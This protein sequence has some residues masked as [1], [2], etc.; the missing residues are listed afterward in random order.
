M[1]QKKTTITPMT[2]RGRGRGRAREGFGRS[3]FEASSPNTRRQ[4]RDSSGSSDSRSSKRRSSPE[5]GNNPNWIPL[6]NSQKLKSKANAKSMLSRVGK[7]R[8]GK[9]KQKGLRGNNE[10]VPYF[11][12]ESRGMTVDNDLATRERK[13]KRA[14]RFASS[15]AKQ[16]APRKQIK[17]SSLNDQL[18]SSDNIEE[19]NV[20]WESWHIVGTCEDLEK[21]FL[22]LTTAPEP[23]NV[24]P[25][26]VLKKSL[27]MTINHWK[28]KQ[29]YH[30]ACDQMKSIR[31]DLTV[32]STSLSTGSM[33][34]LFVFL[35]CKGFG[36]HSL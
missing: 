34:L 35:R 16:T 7:T 2:I 31:Q 9:Q 36:N 23:H 8:G 14:A 25:L 17:L 13:Q 26:E 10:E 4:R 32:S 27:A 29:D 28:Q 33:F 6:G 5:Y 11:Y 12:S 24:R 18:L 22:R 3:R 19:S 15:E 1:V 20:N 21:P 30:Y